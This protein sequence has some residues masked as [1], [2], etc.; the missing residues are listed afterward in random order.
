M[1]AETMT[2]FLRSWHAVGKPDPD[3]ETG[4]IAA[5]NGAGLNSTQEERDAAR[6]FLVELG[7]PQP[8]VVLYAALSHQEESLR[9]QREKE[10]ADQIRDAMGKAAQIAE[11]TRFQDRAG[12]KDLR[13]PVDALGAILEGL[14]ALYEP[15]S[16][17]LAPDELYRFGAVDGLPLDFLGGLHLP[18]PGVTVIGGKSGAGKTTAMINAVRALLAQG[19]RVAFFSYEQSRQDIALLLA[20]SIM[21]AG[22]TE[23]ISNSG[24]YGPMSRF[25]APDDGHITPNQVIDDYTTALKRHIQREGPPAFLREAYRVVT[26]AI[27]SG[28]LELWD[29]YGHIGELARRIQTSNYDTYLVDYVQVVPA[30]PGAP[31]EGYQRIA[32]IAG[33]FRRLSSSQGKTIVLGAQMNR[34]GG[35]GTDP[36]H[37]IPS[38]E[39]FRESADIEHLATMA[40]ALGWY[41]ADKGVK[42]YYWRILKHR[43]NGAARDMCMLSGGQFK[44]CYVQRWSQW[45]SGSAFPHGIH[46]APQMAASKTVGSNKQKET[47]AQRYAKGATQ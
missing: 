34:Q 38:M 21:A 7:T 11:E 14:T 47:K 17:P 36:N 37:Y 44:Y 22:R 16:K 26:D 29:Y 43:Y 2:R 1:N 15:Q 42:H 24:D 30:A 33:E 32:E 5:L 39:Q 45:V 19:K 41:R 10:Q 35:E 3:D 23:P 9:R 6:A 8:D 13:A 4:M 40:L 20:L 31:R 18:S 27:V 46:G 12:L 25:T 28:Q